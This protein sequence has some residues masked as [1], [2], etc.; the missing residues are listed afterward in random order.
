M[1]K[2]D[3]P[4]EK[5]LGND[6]LPVCR[7]V[8][9]YSFTLIELL[10]VIAII[11]ILAGMLLPALNQAREKGRSADCT[12]KLKQIG[13]ATAFY[14]DEN[15]GYHMQADGMLGFSGQ[16]RLW[17]YQLIGY[18]S[19]T[20]GDDTSVTQIRNNI[21]ASKVFMCP[22]VQ[23][24]YTYASDT[25]SPPYLGNYAMLVRAGHHYSDGIGWY[26]K[27]TRN[28]DVAS[29]LVIQDSPMPY[30][31]TGNQTAASV[32][33]YASNLGN[34]GNSLQSAI[35]IMP[36]RHTK[37]FNTL[38]GDGH[39]GSFSRYEIKTSQIDWERKK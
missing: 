36:F 11:A 19:G 31:P 12:G 16:R 10:V 6:H 26:V 9:L 7:Q 39:V 22:T 33:Y 4:L 24:G 3:L 2:E 25:T 21:A 23:T 35:D 32:G 17:Y 13:M 20:R 15:D 27:P 5:S 29:K 37:K 18:L 34:P 28:K 1:K 8:K 14:V 38:L 30:I